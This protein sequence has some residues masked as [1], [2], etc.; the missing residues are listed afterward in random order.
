VVVHVVASG[1]GMPT[2]VGFV[3][4][5]AVGNA[6]TRNLVQRRLRAAVLPRV[7]ERPNGWDV[8]VRALPT[9]ANVT[10]AALVADLDGAWCSAFKRSEASTRPT[11]SADGSGR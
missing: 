11:V 5:K 8:V 7:A 10:F 9:S 6:V 2:R 4:S 1:D 3:V